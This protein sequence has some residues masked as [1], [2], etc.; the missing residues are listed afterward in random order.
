[1]PAF[2]S[3][4]FVPACLRNVGLWGTFALLFVLIGCGPAAP[5]TVKVKGMVTYN[6]GKLNGGTIAFTPKDTSPD[7]Q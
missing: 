2:R 3:F 6:G 7:S 4:H 5:K 1:M